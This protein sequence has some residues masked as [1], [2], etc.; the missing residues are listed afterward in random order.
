MTGSYQVFSK[1]SSGYGGAEINLYFLAREFAKDPNIQVEFLVGD[2]GQEKVEIIE[3]VKLIKIN[4]LNPVLYNNLYHKII[5]RYNF[6]KEVLLSR[7][8]IFIASTAGEFLGYLVFI[9]RYLKRKKILF[10]V[11]HDWDVDGTR[12][13]Q[14]NHIGFLYRY[15]LTRFHRIIVQNIKQKNILWDRYKLDSEVIKNGFPIDKR[16]NPKS[17]K[18]I[19]WVG[20]VVPFKRP[21]IFLKLAVAVPEKSFLMILSGEKKMKDQLKAESKYIKNLEIKD[22][23]GFFEISR[24]FNE[25]ECLVNTSSAEGFPNTFIQSGMSRIPIL[26][27]NVNPDNILTKYNIGFDCRENFLKAKNFLR[28]LDHLKFSELGENNFKYVVSHHNLSDKVIRY[29]KVIHE[30]FRNE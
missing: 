29:K 17:R 13:Q 1:A 25:A 21:E 7:S 8:D 4:R 28:K 12:S 23:I 18:Y 11:G 10:R 2:F 14:N 27:F 15:A 6:V 30:M 9:V 26:S 19:L 20:R 3:N 5:R 24:F 22:A 16:F